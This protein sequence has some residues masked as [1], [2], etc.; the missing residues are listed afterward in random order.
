ME[1]RDGVAIAEAES[2]VMKTKSVNDDDFADGDVRPL[3]VS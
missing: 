3:V 2:A 1:V